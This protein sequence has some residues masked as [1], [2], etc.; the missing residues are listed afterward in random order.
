MAHYSSTGIIRTGD[1]ETESGPRRL[2]LDRDRESLGRGSDP[3][4]PGRD[5]LLV[6]PGE[7]VVVELAHLAIERHAH[8]DLEGPRRGRRAGQDARR[9]V[10]LEPVRPLGQGEGQ[11]LDVPEGGAEAPVH[12]AI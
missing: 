7:R 3:L 12:L 9:G 1:S 5:D 2:L 6:A 10:D 4:R 11:L 8:F